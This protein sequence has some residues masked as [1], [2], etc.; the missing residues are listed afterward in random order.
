MHYTCY[1]STW[2]F[3]SWG[4]T[5]TCCV[6]PPQK[7]GCLV[8]PLSPTNAA[9]PHRQEDDLHT[10]TPAWPIN[11]RRDGQW[12]FSGLL[13]CQASTTAPLG[14]QWKW[15]V[16]QGLLIL[17]WLICI[18]FSLLSLGHTGLSEQNPAAGDTRPQVSLHSQCPPQFVWPIRTHP[19]RFASGIL[20]QRRPLDPAASFLITQSSNCLFTCLLHHT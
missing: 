4:T 7:P 18:S 15:E 1:F 19:F 12:Q 13:A 11:S 17:P 8:L 10:W 14:T 20:P 5:E 2:C 3:Q 9:S 6:L 16:I